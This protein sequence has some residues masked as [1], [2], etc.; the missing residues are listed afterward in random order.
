MTDEPIPPDLEVN[1]PL[2]SGLKVTTERPYRILLMTD[3][4]GSQDGKLSGPLTDG[5]VEVDADSFDEIMSTARPSVYFKTTDPLAGGNVMIEVELSFDSLKAFQPKALLAQLPATK[6]LLAIREQIVAR[7]HG[8]LSVEQLTDAVKQAVA[9]KPDLAWVADVIKWTPSAEA[10]SDDVVDNLLG[11][12]DLGDETKDET[13]KPPPKTPIGAAVA[14]AATSGGRQLP[15]E[16]T[17]ALRRTLAQID[18]QASTWLGAVLHAAPVQRVEAAWRALAFLVAHIDFRKHIRL[19]VLHASQA[20]LT[21]RLTSRV[22]DPVFDEG[23]DA[24]DLIVVDAQFSNSAADIEIL[25]ELAQHGASLP[26]VVLA[27]ASPEFLG[28]KHA[29]Q[30]PSLP[31]IVSVFD[32]WQFAKWKTLR[33]QRYARALGVVFGRCLLRSPF[34]STGGDELEFSYREECLTDKDFVWSSGVI[35]GACTVAKSMAGIG[36]PSG[37]VGRFDGFATGQGGKKGD[38][39]FGPADTQMP[40]DKTQELIAGGL[41]AVV[42]MQ[43]GT[44]VI[45]CNGFS[46]AKPERAEGYA[47]LEVSLPYQLFA[48][49]LSSLL[50]DL[51]P[52]LAG[53]SQDKLVAFVLTHVRDW[54]TMDGVAP[55]EQ[56]VAVQARP[57]EDAPNVLQLAVTVTPPPRIVPGGVPVVVGYRV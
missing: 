29:W 21:E 15:A 5:V 51:K 31:A 19:S 49:R 13:S 32:Q 17:S 28:V 43:D 41:N 10:P 14:A 39:R 18:R 36:W 4:A 20:G 3:L 35:A 44:E 7:M 8:K 16:E 1:F 55:E 33:G 34:T 53:M 27:G 23:A 38:K 6:A 9:A 48:G 11:Q 12:L 52:H 54:L 57:P 42:H 24:P 26:A 25:D 50:L 30:V 40:L 46:A 37:I 47:M 56:Q 45:F 2:P 22:I